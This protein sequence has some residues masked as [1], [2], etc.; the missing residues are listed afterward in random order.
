[1][2]DIHWSWKTIDIHDGWLYHVFCIYIYICYTSV[3]ILAQAWERSEFAHSLANHGRCSRSHQCWWESSSCASLW[4]CDYCRTS[5][6]GSRS[7]QGRGR[8]RTSAREGSAQGTRECFGSSPGC[9]TDDFESQASDPFGEDPGKFQR[10]T[11]RG[12]WN[13]VLSPPSPAMVVC[14]G[15]D[16]W[17]SVLRIVSGH[18]GP[19]ACWIPTDTSR[20]DQSVDQERSCCES[21][22]GCSADSG[23]SRCI[24]EP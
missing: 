13:V 9:R 22:A 8:T 24:C 4:G 7:N 16:A 14:G 17:S 2:I 18:W 15:C 5:R 6:S 21:G 19:A 3:A 12:S 1:M 20:R 11:R 23:G 10:F